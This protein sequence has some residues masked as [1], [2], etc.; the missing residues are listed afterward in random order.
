MQR[1]AAR[2]RTDELSASGRTPT[3]SDTT[4]ADQILAQIEAVLAE[5]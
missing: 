5:A 2:R 3:S 1:R 4:G